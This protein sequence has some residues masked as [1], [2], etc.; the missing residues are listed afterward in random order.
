M[1]RNSEKTGAFLLYNSVMEFMEFVRKTY[2]AYVCT[3]D[4]EMPYGAS[5]LSINRGDMFYTNGK[6]VFIDD[7]TFVEMNV[8]EQ[9]VLT[10]KIRKK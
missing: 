4:F 6:A 9:A 5:Y 3:R 7:E 10:G 2:K 8:F 1:H